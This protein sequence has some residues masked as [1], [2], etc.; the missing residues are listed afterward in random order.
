MG[1]W[2]AKAVTLEE[3]EQAMAVASVLD[4]NG[5]LTKLDAN[6]GYKFAAN[7]PFY[8]A[9]GTKMDPVFYK[10]WL[11]LQKGIPTKAGKVEFFVEQAAEREIGMVV[12]Q[13]RQ[14]NTT[15]INGTGVTGFRDLTHATS[16]LLEM[17]GLPKPLA[18]PLAAQG[19]GKIVQS[20]QGGAKDGYIY[21]KEEMQIESYNFSYGLLRPDEDMGGTIVQLFEFSL[22]GEKKENGHCMGLFQYGSARAELL[23]ETAAILIL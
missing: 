18:Q 7:L 2:S 16:G 11:Q 20:I 12:N 17:V 10:N 5:M 4:L 3:F 9:N 22:Q 1:A 8:M 6:S 23:V 19:V 14:Q 13:A 21:W 15:T